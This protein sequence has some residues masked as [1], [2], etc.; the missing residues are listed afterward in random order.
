MTLDSYLEW[1]GLAVCENGVKVFI[2]PCSF[3]VAVLDP[4]YTL[5][6]SL[7]EA[8]STVLLLRISILQILLAISWTIRVVTWS[9]FFVPSAYSRHSFRN[10]QLL[11]GIALFS[12]VTSR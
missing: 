3:G 7:S 4:S 11:S 2:G 6:S 1:M 12:M 9:F 8:E 5:S 10:V